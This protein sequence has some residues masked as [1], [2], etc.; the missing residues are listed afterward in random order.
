MMIGFVLLAASAVLLFAG[1]E[2]FAEHAAEAGVRLGVSA[3][4]VGVLLA[5]AEL[6]IGRLVWASVGAERSGW[7]SRRRVR[8]RAGHCLS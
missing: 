8:S 1:A 2:L 7:I 6:Q 5:G 4:A 3:L